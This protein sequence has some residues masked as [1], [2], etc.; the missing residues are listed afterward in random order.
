M[1]EGGTKNS[2]LNSERVAPAPHW[3]GPVMQRLRSRKMN[4]ARTNTK[5]LAD[6]IPRR[7]RFPIESGGKVAAATYRSTQMIGLGGDWYGV[8]ACLCTRKCTDTS[9][10]ELHGRPALIGL[11]KGLDIN[12]LHPKERSHRPL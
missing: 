4:A 9:A 2:S 3:H 12:L 8:S 1:A 7:S 6:T 11:P 10:A 5:H